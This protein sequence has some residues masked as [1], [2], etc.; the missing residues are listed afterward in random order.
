VSEQI[1]LDYNATTPVA[2]EVLEVMLPW[3]SEKF[4]N[5]A[6]AHGPG[7]TASAVVDQARQQ[8]AEA[9]GARSSEI[10]FTSGAT[11]ANNLAIKGVM[12]VAPPS[13]NR[14]LV[15]ATEHKAVLDAAGWLRRQGSTVE[16]VPV[17]DSGAVE[18][19]TLRSMLDDSVA[20]V[21]VMVANNETGVIS[22]IADLAAATHDAGAV[23]HT[24]A[25][26]AL[27]RLPFDV[28]VLGVDL[29]SFSAHKLYG[30][31]GVGALFINRRTSLEAQV[32]G[33][34]HERGF[35]SGTLNVPGI[36]GFG[37]AA[38]RASASCSVEALHQAELVERL[39]SRLAER[40]AS[41]EVVAR[42]SNR[43]PNTANIHFAGA[44]AE[45]VMA[46]T[47]HIAVSSGS[48]CTSAIP[49]P[50]HVLR[51]MGMSDEA[52]YECLRI[53]VG[54]PTTRDEIDQAAAALAVSVDRVRSLTSAA[55]A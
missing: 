3:F 19:D 41:F 54:A 43:L 42:R 25:T 38:E 7:S 4:W 31:K 28:R 6:S 46:S 48:A 53:S 16:I 26:Q 24:D 12:G 44:D 11:E 27:G 1:Y 23:F 39:L 15:G 22:P 51:A 40:V 13:R 50:S 49:T 34:G 8:V 55:S 35:R 52:A 14:V 9:I 45:A 37:A 32:H 17:G 10:V 21:S 18:L 5:A 33:G 20:I 2:P 29:A 47:P 30:P 36:V